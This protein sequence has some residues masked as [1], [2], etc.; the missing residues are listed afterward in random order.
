MG[1]DI[2][3]DRQR[4]FSKPRAWKLADNPHSRGGTINGQKK[5]VVIDLRKISG[6][7][8]WKIF[9]GNPVISPGVRGVWDS[10]NLATMNI[11]KVENA[12]HIYYEGGSIGVEDF[13]IGHAVS[14]DGAIWKKD[15]GNP[16]VPFGQD[17]DWDDRETWDPFVIHEQGAYK[18]CY[19][20]TTIADAR[21]FLLKTEPGTCFTARASTKWAINRDAACAL[22]CSTD[23]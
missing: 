19:G 23:V 16:V 5:Y 3:S 6:R 20:G 2:F 9:S 11:L 17:G 22:R 8:K 21:T 13:Q 18:M 14:Q 10:W 15:P 12:C 7:G 4:L 1:E